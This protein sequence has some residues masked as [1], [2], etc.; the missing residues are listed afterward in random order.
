FPDEIRNK[1]KLKEYCGF[2]ET[3]YG[4][5]RS[6][7]EGHVLDA[8]SQ[9]L[10]SIHHWAH[11]VLIEEGLH[12]ELTVWKQLRKVHPGISKLYE[13]LIA[14]PETI[15]QRVELVMLACEFSAMNKMKG[16]CQFLIDIMKERTTSWSISE[17][18]A[19]DQLTYIVDDM[20][21]VIQ[22]LVQGHI[23]KE[24]AA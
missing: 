18:Q 1:R 20:S 22:K 9:I 7:G 2:L 17:L 12:P 3:L 6:L 23:L 5:K 16:C 24:V 15:E 13:E 8:Y 19:E 11:I 21:L 14:S 10:V 4:A